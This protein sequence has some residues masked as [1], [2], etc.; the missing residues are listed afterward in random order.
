MN[1]TIGKYIILLGVVLMLVGL[2]IYLFGDKLDWIGHLPGD[3]RIN[4]KN[5][6]GFYFPIV[7]CLVVSLLLNLFIVLIRRFF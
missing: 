7:T 1:P 5:G 2:L 4:T 3:I 6:G